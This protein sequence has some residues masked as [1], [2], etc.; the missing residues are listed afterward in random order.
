MTATAATNVTVSD[1]DVILS[2]KLLRE[3]IKCAWRIIEPKPF[4]GN[5]HIDAVCEHLEAVT[6][7]QI[8]NLIINIPP[9]HTKS[10]TVSVMWPAWEWGPKNQPQTRWLFTSY[11]SDLSVRD[12]VKCRRLIQ[13][14]WYQALWGNRFYL[15]GDQNAK[16]RYN[17]NKNGYRI[18]SSVGGVATG[19][20]GDRLVVDD[21]HNIGQVTSDQIRENVNNWWD[22]V[23]TTR[24]NDPNE[25]GRV[26]IMQRSHDRDLVGHIKSKAGSA[27]E[28]LVLPSEY[29]PKSKCVTSI[30]FK[31]PRKHPGELLWK[32]RFNEAAIDALKQGLGSYAYAAQ[33]QQRPSPI[34]GGLFKRQWWRYYKESPQQI[35]KE[36]EFL[37]Q[38]WDL[39]F[40]DLKTSDYVVGQVWGVRGSDRILL[41]QVRDQLSFTAS[42]QAIKNLSSKW[43]EAAGKYIEDK[44]N[45]PAIIDDLRSEVPGLIAW[46]PETSKESRAI[47]VTP[48]CEAGNV[49]L[50]DP[51]TFRW[52]NDLIEELASFNKGA[53]DDQVDALTQALLII[54]KKLKTFSDFAPVISLTKGST[55]TV[56]VETGIWSSRL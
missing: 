7:G 2:E 19:E 43:P 14:S 46:N 54:R 45:G 34:E 5:W 50:P 12:S 48:E 29:E 17:N 25:G 35:A 6:H 28:Y 33:H 4:V 1:I 51:H 55:R 16:E 11:G 27:Y 30:G 37:F 42:K 10:M 20:G 8:R 15:M 49:M 21:P 39:T 22:E 44:A 36:C 53:H 3:F 24:V 31:D 41:D 38:S 40:K 13:S 26:I 9:R 52:V 32:N 23:M 56:E 47:S 18:A